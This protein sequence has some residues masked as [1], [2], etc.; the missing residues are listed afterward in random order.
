M[1][2]WLPKYHPTAGHDN[3]PLFYNLQRNPVP[4]V[5]EAGWSFWSREK[6]SHYGMYQPASGTDT[7]L[8]MLP[9]LKNL[10]LIEDM[11]AWHQSQFGMV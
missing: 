11:R 4:T 5:Q 1:T 6:S 8:T 2:Y 3:R 9:R 10:I 7:V